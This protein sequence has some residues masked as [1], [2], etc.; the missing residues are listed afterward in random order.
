MKDIDWVVI[1]LREF[2]NKMLKYIISLFNVKRN[3]FVY[4]MEREVFRECLSVMFFLVFYF[5][6]VDNV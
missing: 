6:F 5:Y 2:D 1:V 4:L 3:K